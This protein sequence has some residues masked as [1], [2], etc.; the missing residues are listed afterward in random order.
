[1]TNR[2]ILSIAVFI[3]GLCSI[4][5]ELLI[6]TTAT[7][8][9]GDG[10]RQF[11]II[12]GVYLFSMGVG[13]YFAKMMSIKSLRNFVIIEYILGW[14]GAISVPLLYFVFTYVSISSFQVICLAQIFI[15]GFLTGTEVPLLTFS[16]SDDNIKDNLSTVLSLDYV[17]GL[18]AT[19]IF[20]FVILPF[21]GL[22]YASLSFGFINI[23]LG[24][25][26]N[27]I[28]FKNNKKMLLGGI[29]SLVSIL[30]LV[31]AGGQFMKV[32]EERIYKAPVIV[33]QQ[34][35]YQKIVLT[36]KGDQVKLF[37]NRVIQFASLDEH[38]YHESLVHVPFSL[39]VNEAQKVLVLG[40]GE[41]LATR[42]I[43]K[44]PEVRQIDIVDIDSAIFRLALEHHEISAINQLAPFDPRVN[45]V[46]DDA[47]S[48]MHRNQEK[49]DI[50][51]ADL[52]D[53]NNQSLARLYS[54]QF[55]HYAKRTLKDDGVFITQSGDINTSNNV[56]SCI[57]T[58]MNEVFSGGL[59]TYHVYIPSFGDWGFVIFSNNK[60]PDF[61]RLPK[62]LKYLDQN[63]LL[64]NFEL[65]RDV[66]ISDV[67]TNTLDHPV[68]LD[69]FL[70]DHTKFKENSH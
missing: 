13:A 58:T 30:T 34:T 7:Y 68:I 1:M 11:S 42:E 47:F 60:V 2:A 35:P 19:L 8:F 27:F 16:F 55:F 28:F 31:L 32:W 40:G 3:A 26:V 37:I 56:F 20:P 70:D 17:G 61:G 52:P 48:F 4:I 18:I 44:Y 39:K 49:Y 45:L 25:G 15:I 12:I 38:R 66:M 53:P 23:L 54:T 57:Y 65:P 14:V 24:L 9:L 21:V 6:S 63:A 33:N 64:N 29:L 50:I 43:V 62:G 22:F 5:Y 69:Y 36:K 59:L 67:K 41:N 46:V 10:V 51:I